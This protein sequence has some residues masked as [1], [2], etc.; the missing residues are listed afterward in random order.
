MTLGLRRVSRAER[1][2]SSVVIRRIDN[3]ELDVPM[4]GQALETIRLVVGGRNVRSN[5]R[6]RG[7]NLTQNVDPAAYEQ[8]IESCDVDFLVVYNQ[9]KPVR[10]F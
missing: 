8:G 3:A 4:E 9:S 1:I 2:K 6:I 10:L 5:D 7:E